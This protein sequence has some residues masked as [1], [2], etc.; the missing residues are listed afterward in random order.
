MIH[1]GVPSPSAHEGRGRR[2]QEVPMSSTLFSRRKFF[3]AG[4]A[5]AAAAGVAAIPGAAFARQPQEGGSGLEP[6]FPPGGA[7]RFF[8]SQQN[9]YLFLDTM[10]DAYERGFTTRLSQSYSDELGLEST[11]FVYDNV[12]IMAR[13]L[14]ASG[15]DLDRAKVLGNGLLYAQ[16]TDPAADGRVRQAYFVDHADA[17][18]AFV[19]PSGF[20]FFFLGSATG[21]VAW[22]GMALAQL[23]NRT[24]I[25]AYLDGAVRLGN[26][27]FNNTF[28]TR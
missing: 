18:G 19:I 21:D 24:R 1:R 16:Q 3:E 2:Q 5:A 12:E 7:Q 25:Q 15:Q 13:L 8:L 11:A 23:A 14:R 6:L 4:T 20:P 28:D 26:W 17:N 27:I 9:A 22:T 10:M